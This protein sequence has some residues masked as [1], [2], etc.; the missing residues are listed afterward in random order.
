MNYCHLEWVR[1]YQW[2]CNMDPSGQAAWV[3]AI[4][5][6]MAIGVAIFVPYSQKKREL[7]EQASNNRKIVMSA[8]ANLEFALTY[9]ST[10]FDFA[11][12]GDGVITQELTL[13]QA[14]QLM[15]LRPQTREALQSAIDK[16]HYFSVTLCEQIVRLGI[17]STS[18]ERIVDDF[19]RRTTNADAFFKLIQNTKTKFS[20]RL[21]KVRQLLQEYLPKPP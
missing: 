20:E 6:I 2:W 18:Y 3:Q 11:P 12:T 16:S 7:K 14:H 21:E 8:A 10:L 5:S 1:V 13:D 15:K 19:A 17:E 9:Q 4:G